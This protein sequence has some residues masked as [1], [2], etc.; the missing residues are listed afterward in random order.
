M[1]DSR[2]KEQDGN[3]ELEMVTSTNKAVYAAFLSYN[4]RWNMWQRNPNT[5]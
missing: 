5:H 4:G 2:R 1:I 3:C